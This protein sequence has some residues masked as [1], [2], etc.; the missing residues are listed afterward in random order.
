MSV[1]AFIL[2]AALALLNHDSVAIAIESTLGSDVPVW[3]GTEPVTLLLLGTDQRE[4]ESG[5]S[6][7]DTMILAMFDPETKHVAML[8]IPR[9]LWVTIPGYGDTRI[10]TAF[11]RGQAYDV[12]NGGPGLAALTVEY[13]FGV[14]VDYWATVDFAGFER[15]IDALGGVT[16]NVP[17]EI[18]DYEYPDNNNG[19]M[20]ISF[21]PGEQT[22]DGK[23]ALQYARTRHGSSDFDRA[24]RQQQI[25]AAVK[26]RALSPQVLPRL[27][28]VVQALSGTVQTNADAQTILALAGFARNSE[29]MTLDGRVIDESLAS[30]YVTDTGAYVLLPDWAG[31]NA[32]VQELF[33]PRLSEGQPLANVGIRIENA[34]DL[35]GLA[36]QTASFL[37]TRGAIVTEVTDRGGSNE[38]Y[39][40]VYAPADEA[41][42][43][44]AKLYRV[45]DDRIIAAQD[46]PPQTHVTLVLGWD[47][48]S[49]G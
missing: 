36:G 46:G 10:N 5:P 32:L 27:P 33:A 40:Y 48:I 47:V 14:P 29:G 43:Y 13:N 24:R 44:L 4:G 8:S 9:D 28:K 15:I 35:P 19:V 37:Q 2:G 49:G 22:M 34:T 16:V 11:F 7:S 31:I 42:D 17:N 39:I 38:S 41:V 45:S 26:E 12:A 30:N 20:T 18:V 23:T 1:V 6:R 21:T 25:I 3:S